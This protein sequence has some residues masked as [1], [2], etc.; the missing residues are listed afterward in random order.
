VDGWNK[1]DTFYIFAEDAIA[2]CAF[3]NPQT[4]PVKH[5]LD[6]QQR[7]KTAGEL[8]SAILG[9]LNLNR[10]SKLS[11]LTKMVVWGE[12]KLEAKISFPKVTCD[13][14]CKSEVPPQQL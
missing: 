11:V 14:W 3:E 10:E 8:N 4:C 9:K 13:T 7:Q 6:M 12:S 2:L 1:R 5:L